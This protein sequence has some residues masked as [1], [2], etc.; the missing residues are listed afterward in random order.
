MIMVR[1]KSDRERER[2]GE[3]GRVREFE[4]KLWNQKREIFQSLFVRSVR[5]SFAS[6]F[7]AQ[8]NFLKCWDFEF[9][10][11]FRKSVPNNYRI[12]VFRFLY[13]IPAGF[14]IPAS[15]KRSR[16]K[17]V[18]FFIEVQNEKQR[19]DFAGDRTDLS[20][21]LVSPCFITPNTSTIRPKARK[22]YKKA[23]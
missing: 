16:K 10:S 8:R 5:R 19:T 15:I 22:L 17:G 11:R 21:G 4:E 20:S 3:K 6:Y 13:P 7:Q 9:F 18:F 1:L 23:G 14:F 2:G 12:P